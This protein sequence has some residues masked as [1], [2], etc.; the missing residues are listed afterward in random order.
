[1]ESALDLPFKAKLVI[2]AVI[3]NFSFFSLFFIGIPIW[4]SEPT[5]LCNGIKCHGEEACREGIIDWVTTRPNPSTQFEMYCDRRY[6][7][8]YMIGALVFGGFIGCFLKIFILISKEKRI[9][10]TAVM[11]VLGI[12]FLLISI[13]T[14]SI[15]VWTFVI[16]GCFFIFNF[17]L[18][19]Y[20]ALCNENLPENIAK[21]IVSLNMFMWPF[22]G[23]IIVGLGWVLNMNW[24]HLHLLYI[25][26]LIFAF[27]GKLIGKFDELDEKNHTHIP[28]IINTPL[29]KE[30][31]SNL[32]EEDSEEEVTYKPEENSFSA[33][34]HNTIIVLLTWYTC[35]G[36]SLG[37]A[38][39]LGE[40]GDNPF[41]NSTFYLLFE[42]IGCYACRILL[43][44]YHYSTIMGT[45]LKCMAGI[46]I[47]F[48]FSTPSMWRLYLFLVLLLKLLC[49][50]LATSVIVNLPHFFPKIFLSKIVGASQLLTRFAGIFMARAFTISKVNLGIHPFVFMGL[51]TILNINMLKRIKKID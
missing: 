36:T 21:S 41:A 22:G 23:M 49:D 37:T 33:N 45:I 29:L 35:F 47:V 48:L 30:V 20:I 3:M 5:F 16:S 51:I 26:L 46:Q 12:I 9:F 44:R 19:E 10:Y 25:M 18:G 6:I 7:K 27:I 31:V 42:S 40:L 14:S 1:M 17:T 39:E 15:Y 38:I 32:D 8:D 50:S 4:T 24:K 43:P 2:G 34:A 11:D 13:S 28:S